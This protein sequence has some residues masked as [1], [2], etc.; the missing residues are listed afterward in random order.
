MDNFTIKR[1]DTMQKKEWEQLMEESRTEGIRHLTKVER[2]YAIGETLELNR[3]E[4]LFGAYH[5]DGNLLAIGGLSKD[6]YS[7]DEETGRIR[8]LYV[9]P[10][11][12]QKGMGS[13]LLGKIMEYAAYHYEWLVVM[14]DTPRASQFYFSQGF[15]ETVDH[16]YATHFLKT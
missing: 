16:A 14:A 4:A 2:E 5:M 3:G 9:S 12:R 6:P 7:N 1:I 15:L 13:Q 10:S 11:Y 8:R